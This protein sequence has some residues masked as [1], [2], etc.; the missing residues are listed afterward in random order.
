MPAVFVN[1]SDG[2]GR[3]PEMIGQEL[4][5]LAGFRGSVADATQTQ[6]L[7]LACGLDDRVERNAAFAAH[8]ATLQ[9]RVHS[10]PFQAGY[11][12]NALFT[13]PPKP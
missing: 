13:E 2:S 1:I 7:A 12:K 5:M 6:G 8:R 4:V 10:V 11:E 9:K 3:K